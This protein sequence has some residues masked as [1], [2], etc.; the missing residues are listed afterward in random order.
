MAYKHVK[1]CSTS[2]VIK[3][4]QIKTTRRY[5]Y[6]PIPMVKIQNTD[7]GECSQR[8]GAKGTLI[9]CWWERKTVQPFWKIVWQ[10]ITKLIMLSP[11]TLVITLLVFIQR[12]LKLD[13]HKNLHIGLYTSFITVAKT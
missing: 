9:H 13:L 3:E 1:K 8:C 12:G 2:Y 5:Y 11:Y 4:M 6:T 7:N 10:L